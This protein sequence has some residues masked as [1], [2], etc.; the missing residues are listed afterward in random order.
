MPVRKVL[1]LSVLFIISLN[2][3][4]DDN[5]LDYSATIDS[6][7]QDVMII[8]E[9]DSY[10]YRLLRFK[11]GY[12]H[13]SVEIIV[14]KYELSF[15][16]MDEPYILLD[17]ISIEELGN[18]YY[19]EID[20]ISEQKGRF[21]IQLSGLHTYSYEEVEVE[22]LIDPDLNYDVNITTISGT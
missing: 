20:S 6:R 15:I 10:I 17:S 8:S 21:K 11:G 3:Y 12:E 18:F 19:L 2:A 14:Q 4:A 1:I 16:D 5:L 7:L 9:N 22:L 13:I